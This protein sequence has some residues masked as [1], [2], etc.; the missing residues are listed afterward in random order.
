MLK[1]KYNLLEALKERGYSTYRLRKDRLLSESTIQAFRRGDT[2]VALENIDRVCRLMGGVQP[3]D[4]LEWLPDQEEA[5][6]GGVERLPEAS[7]EPDRRDRF[8]SQEDDFVF[9]KL[10]I[11]GQEVKQK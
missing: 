2:A 3:G 4:L 11:D 10:V 1:Y 8:A 5:P 7:D 9:E 6:T